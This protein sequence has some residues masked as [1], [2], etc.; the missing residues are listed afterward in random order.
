M[1][2]WPIRIINTS[3]SESVLLSNQN[4]QQ[5][6]VMLEYVL[7]VHFRI[8][9]R[10]MSYWSIRVSQQ[11]ISVKLERFFW[12]NQNIQPI[13]GMLKCVSE[14]STHLCLVRKCLNGQSKSP[15]HQCHRGRLECVYWHIWSNQI[16]WSL[17]VFTSS[18]NWT[19]QS[20]TKGK[21]GKT[22]Y[23]LWYFY[24]GHHDIK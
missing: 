11:H 16:G 17:A 13:S 21:V 7:M 24:S 14:A 19:I 12:T 10:P 3:M 8:N 15:T 4:Q 20:K 18:F 9:N 23:S 6:C 5:V 2:F 22:K 1:P